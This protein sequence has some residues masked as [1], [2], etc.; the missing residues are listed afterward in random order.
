MVTGVILRRQHSLHSVAA[1]EEFTRDYWH[2]PGRL[3]EFTG[4][5]CAPGGLPSRP[6]C[7]P[8][9][10]SHNLAQFSTCVVT[11]S[12]LAACLSLCHCLYKENC[13][14]QLK[15]GSWIFKLVLSSLL[16]SLQEPGA[17]VESV[18][19]L[20]VCL[21]DVECWFW[22]ALSKSWETLES[23]MLEERESC[24]PVVG[25][26]ERRAGSWKRR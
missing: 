11:V 20:Q 2:D 15:T 10:S 16:L 17:A 8:N 22:R 23:L 5:Y 4:D 9:C 3:L 19:E 24:T 21:A 18:T 14:W 25:K 13:F 12:R 1:R 6:S 7:I 26:T